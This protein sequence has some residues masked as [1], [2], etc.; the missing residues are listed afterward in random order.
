MDKKMDKEIEKMLNK[1][2]YKNDIIYIKRKVLSNKEFELLKNYLNNNNVKY[3]KT[4]NNFLLFEFYTVSQNKSDIINCLSNL[5]DNVSFK[6]SHLSI[7]C[8]ISLCFSIVHMCL[9]TCGYFNLTCLVLSSIIL[10]RI[11]YLIIFDEQPL[12]KEVQLF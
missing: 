4:V 8:I 6:F 1:C 11:F 5:N 9:N 10:L 2:F 7:L 3:F 12:N